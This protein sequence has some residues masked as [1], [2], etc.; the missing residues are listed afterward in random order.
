MTGGLAL[1]LATSVANPG[2]AAADTA[3]D[4]SA[5]GTIMWS[6]AGMEVGAAGSLAYMLGGK[7]ATFSNGRVLASTAVPLVTAIGA[8]LLAAKLD[9]GPRL[10]NAVHGALWG[11]LGAGALGMVID[12][13]RDSSGAKLGPATKVLAATGAVAFAASSAL[14]PDDQMHPIFLGAPMAAALGTILV[15]GVALMVALPD[16]PGRVMATAASVTVLGSLAVGSIAAF[17]ADPV[18]TEPAR[19]GRARTPRAPFVLS[20]GG[21]Y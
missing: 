8:G 13:R 18:I 17:A 6:I 2:Q 1:A 12:G 16:R 21:S 20:L 3:A 4:H 11:A 5:D 7:S 19:E 9:A 14:L 10:G 15:G